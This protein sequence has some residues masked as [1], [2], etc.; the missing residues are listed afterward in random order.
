M[1]EGAREK[2]KGQLVQVEHK[3]QMNQFIAICCVLLY[4]FTI[5]IILLAVQQ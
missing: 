2:N 4:D 3:V 1:K 5:F